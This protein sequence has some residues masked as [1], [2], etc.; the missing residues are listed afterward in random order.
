MRKNCLIWTTKAFVATSNKLSGSKYHHRL[1]S[2]LLSFNRHISIIPSSWKFVTDCEAGTPG[3]EPKVH[4]DQSSGILAQDSD[5]ENHMMRK[6]NTHSPFFNPPNLNSKDV[7]LHQSSNSSS[8]KFLAKQN[9]PPTFTLK[10]LL[11][12]D[13]ICITGKFWLGCQMRFEEASFGSF[14]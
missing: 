10:T 3:L 8:Q 2:I 12:Y 11:G 5:P 4:L 6:S 13:L 7:Y 14:H 9:Y 1:S